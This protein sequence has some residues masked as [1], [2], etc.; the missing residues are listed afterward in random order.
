MEIF[1]SLCHNP[2]SYH[3]VNEGIGHYEYWGAPGYDEQLEVKSDCCDEACLDINKM[4]ITPDE[5][6][7]YED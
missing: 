2:C 3:I 1:C 4:E 7:A 6:N 5:I